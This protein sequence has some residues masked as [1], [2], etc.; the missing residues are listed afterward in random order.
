MERPEPAF[1][2]GQQIRVI[3]SAR[4][5]TAHEGAVREIIWHHKDQRYNYYLEESGK[6]VPKRYFEEDLEAVPEICRVTTPKT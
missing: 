2:I 6:K 4:N 1:H 3:L 5:R